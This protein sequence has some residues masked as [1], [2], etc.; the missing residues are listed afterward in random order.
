MLVF[1]VG[2]DDEL[3]RAQPASPPDAV[4]QVENAASLLGEVGVSGKDPA[5]MPPGTNG[6]FVEPSPDSGIADR[7]HEAGASYVGRELGDAPAGER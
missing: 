2:T 6:V 1:L 5:T 4:V 7:G 3:I